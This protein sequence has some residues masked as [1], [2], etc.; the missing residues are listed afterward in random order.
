[1]LTFVSFKIFLFCG[2]INL[3]RNELSKDMWAG[4]AVLTSFGNLQKQTERQAKI[5]FCSVFP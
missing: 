3:P 4:S 1:M 5:I 2:F